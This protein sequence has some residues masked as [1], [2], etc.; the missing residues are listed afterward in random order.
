MDKSTDGPHDRPVEGSPVLLQEFLSDSV[1]SLRDLHRT[2]GSLVGFTRGSTWVVF[3]F[4][5]EYNRQVLSN[6]EV[7][8][9]FG[10]VP[11]PK[12]SAHRRLGSGL[13]GLNGEKHQ[14]QRRLLMP[15]FRKEAVE[16]YRDLL[17]EDTRQ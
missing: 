2:Y 11:G 13:F 14:H 10:A 16:S 7:F 15:P 12:N 3:C 1:G 6:A 8:Y 17:V 5:P 4:D 9:L